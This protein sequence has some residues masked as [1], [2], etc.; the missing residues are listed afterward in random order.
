MDAFYVNLLYG[1]FGLYTVLLVVAAVFDSWKFIIPNA[2]S[3]AL[4]ALFVATALILPFE[5]DWLSHL[6][7]ALAVFAGGAVLY[8]FGKMGAGDVKLLT[9]VAFWAGLEHLPTFLLYVTLGGGAL[10]IGLMIVRRILLGLQ[11]A[12]PRLGKIKLP[13]ALLTAEPIPYGLAIA[14]GAIFLGAS[15]PHLG[16]FILI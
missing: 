16:A 15:L 11:V 5:V 14:P 12:Q 8:G 4:V 3:V 1:V 9:A 7:A 6:G 13:R 10:A 2:V